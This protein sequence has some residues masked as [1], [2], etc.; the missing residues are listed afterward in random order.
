MP[1]WPTHPI[2]TGS[3]LGGPMLELQLPARHDWTVQ[4]KTY[5]KLAIEPCEAGFALTVSIAYRGPLPSAIPGAAPTWVK[6]ENVLHEFSHLPG[7]MEDTLDIMMNLRNV[8]FALH[9]N[10]P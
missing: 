8:V 1:W 6:I 5:G 4:D 7:V 3:L 9:V 10:R 2:H